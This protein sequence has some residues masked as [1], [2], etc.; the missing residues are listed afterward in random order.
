MFRKPFG[1]TNG[2]LLGIF[3]CALV[4]VCG[5][6]LDSCTEEET[7]NL[8]TISQS[9]PEPVKDLSLE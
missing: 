2:E 8:L 3:A 6:A 5:V 4:G 7:F 9:S 1:I